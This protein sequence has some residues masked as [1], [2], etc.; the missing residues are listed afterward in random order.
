VTVRTAEDRAGEALGRSSG[1]APDTG[2]GVVANLLG[3]GV[4]GVAGILLLLLIAAVHGPEALGRFNLLFAVHLVGSQVATLGLHV[5]VVRHVAPLV[6]G[7]PGRDAATSAVQGAVL[8]TLTTGGL[9]AAALLLGRTVLAGLLGRP[10]L[11]GPLGWVALG[12]LLFSL[13]KVLLATLT[14]FGRLQLHAALAATRG[15]LMLVALAGLTWGGS[16]GEDL[17]LV[18]VLAEA[19]LLVPLVVAL[20]RDLAGGAW[21]RACLPWVGTHVRFG[22]LGAGSSLLTELNIRVDVLVLAFFVDDRAIGIYTLVATLSEAALQVPMVHRTVL[23]PSIVRLLEANDGAGLRALVVRTRTRLWLLMAV[24]AALMVALHPQLVRL[25]G[26]DDG[27]RDGRP[28]LAVLLVGVVIA[29]GYVPFGLLLA[30]A[31]QPLQQTGFVAVLV[32]LNLV[33]NLLLV[34]SLGLLGAAI[35]TAG[36]N[37]ASVPLLRAVAARRLRLAI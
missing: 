10:E 18:L 36:A 9:A 28:V 30:H 32:A 4:A 11:A 16:S 24:I 19:G 2:R 8:A 26:A 23:G 1:P 14:A 25:L 6:A 22:V 29:S 33:G 15:L 35:A 20:R 13:N 5:S 7:Q 3:L 27:F 31:G 12:I 21:T 17:V 37:V 34:P